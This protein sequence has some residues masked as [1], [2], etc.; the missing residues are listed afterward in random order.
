MI[1]LASKLQSNLVRF[2]LPLQPRNYPTTLGLGV[3]PFH[4]LGVR[5]QPVQGTAG[6]WEG[7]SCSHSCQQLLVTELQGQT[8][9][10]RKDPSDS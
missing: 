10:E 4:R 2:S 7:Q 9:G 5:P 3:R 8:T 6:E 1:P